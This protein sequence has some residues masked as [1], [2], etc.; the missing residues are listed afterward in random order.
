MLRISKDGAVECASFW[1]ISSS[2]PGRGG[3]LQVGDA[4]L[5]SR[6]LPLA[7][8]PLGPSLR[9]RNGHGNRRRTGQGSRRRHDAWRFTDVAAGIL[10]IVEHVASRTKPLVRGHDSRRRRGHPTQSLSLSQSRSRSCLPPAP[11]TVINDRRRRRLRYAFVLLAI[12]RTL[13][14]RRT[15]SGEHGGW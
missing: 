15:R 7:S 4:L 11:R 8:R 1:G 13:A 10:L 5:S 6:S 9:G 2:A 12:T 3:D 14:P